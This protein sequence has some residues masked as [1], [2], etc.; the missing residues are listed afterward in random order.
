MCASGRDSGGA[1]CADS[2]Q[3]AVGVLGAVNKV[4]MKA[5]KSDGSDVLWGEHACEDQ[6]LDGPASGGGGLQG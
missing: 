1:G 4:N 2:G 6:V 5:C 3:A